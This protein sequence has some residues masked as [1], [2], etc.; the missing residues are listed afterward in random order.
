MKTRIL[1]SLIATT[2]LMMAEEA[3]VEIKKEETKAFTA[4]VSIYTGI[5][6]NSGET[7]E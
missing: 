7:K 1:L 4:E 2:S 6:N 5:N 3:K